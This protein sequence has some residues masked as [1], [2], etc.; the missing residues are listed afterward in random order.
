MKRS[1]LSLLLLIGLATSAMAQ[2][3]VFLP[4]SIRCYDLNDDNSRWSW[5][6]S[7]QT[8]NVIVFWEKGFG[9]DL[10]NPPMLDGKPMNVDLDNLLQR[11]ETFYAYF[12][13]SLRFTLPGSKAE[14]YKM[15][16]MLNYSLEG[17]AY[18]GTYD[19]FIGALWVA[20]NRVQDRKLNCIAHELG[21]SFQ[22][23]IPADSISDAWGGSGFYEMTS[24]WMLWHVNPHW[25][26]DENYHFEAYR[27]AIHK[28]YLDGENIYRSPY[29]LQYWANKRGNTC[30]ADLYRN[31]KRGED[32]VI[33][34][35]RLY[36]LTQE[37]FN[38]EMIE[39]CQHIVPLDLGHAWDETRRYACTFDTPMQ[40]IGKDT[41][42]PADEVIP[43]DYGFNAIRLQPARA[44]RKVTATIE[45]DATLRYAFVAVTAD[46]KPHYG[47]PV[48][49]GK[50]IMKM[51]RGQ[52][53][54]ALY[55][56]V[57]GAPTQHKMLSWRNR[58]PNRQYPY[59]VKI[60][61]GGM[62]SE[63]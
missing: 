59:E 56:V 6:R 21:H 60:K 57:M 4:D 16:V 37:Q 53:V 39:A 48:S 28:A 61:G 19:N 18:G 38:D 50:A 13:D 32:P 11:I 9:H 25:L 26:T 40:T 12:R 8:D 45:S 46:G 1:Y 58:E 47:T 23:Q 35:Q 22:L 20:P 63:L 44:G 41:Y 5:Q 2:K 42:A 55:L 7:A 24:Q 54:T 36:G 62:N 17:T 14:R 52:E 30:I 10:S 49:S 33:T 43:E 15:M 31:G 27:K 29:V 51:P 3:Q 34:Y